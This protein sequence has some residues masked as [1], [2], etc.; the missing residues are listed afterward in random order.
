MIQTSDIQIGTKR[1]D[2][3]ENV[4]S[5]NLSAIKFPFSPIKTASTLLCYRAGSLVKESSIPC[6]YSDKISSLTE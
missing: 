3:L 5:S 2:I 4:W 6:S 1:A